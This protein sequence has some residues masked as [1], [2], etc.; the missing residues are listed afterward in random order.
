MRNLPWMIALLVGAT[1]SAATPADM[2]RDERVP[3]GIA[4]ISLGVFDTAPQASFADRRVTVV[5]CV[6]GW[7]AVVGL[8]LGLSAGDQRL[9]VSHATQTVDIP[10]V[11]QPKAYQIQRITM[12]EKNFVEPS[13]AEL[14]RI[15][16]DQEILTRAF[17]T[18]SNTIPALRFSLPVT[19][20]LTAR[21]GLKRYFNGQPRAPHSGIDIAAPEGTPVHAPANGT[22]IDTGNYFFNGNTI[23]LDHGEGVITMY[24]HLRRIVVQP[25]VNVT[26]GQEIGEVGRT[27]R[28][29]GPHLHWSVSLNNTRIDPMLLLTPEALEELLPKR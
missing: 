16:H 25:G 6:E 28:V 7:C 29:T 3:G 23:F 26:A 13:A 19:G 21:F 4:V 5:P 2:P 11:V 14:K 24:N 15:A 27:G 17:T 20:R 9:Q 18:W 10:F 8:P 12:R 1:A 22:V